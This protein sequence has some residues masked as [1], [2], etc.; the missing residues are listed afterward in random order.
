[1]GFEVETVGRQSPASVTK[2]PAFPMKRL[3]GAMHPFT[4]KFLFQPR[5]Q[6][7]VRAITC[8]LRGNIGEIMAVPG[9]ADLSLSALRECAAI[10]RAGG[11]PLSAV[12]GP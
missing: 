10:G 7:R 5:I 11:Y 4:F 12:P 2:K 9:G 3:R 8:L 6:I 1:M